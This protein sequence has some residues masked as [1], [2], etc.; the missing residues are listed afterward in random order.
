MHASKLLTHGVHFNPLELIH[1]LREKLP[2]RR[3]K[4]S[5]TDMTVGGISDHKRNPV[6]FGFSAQTRGVACQIHLKQIQ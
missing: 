5:I 1:E 6:S 2:V 3:F 4:K